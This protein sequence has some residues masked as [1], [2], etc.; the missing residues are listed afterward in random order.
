MFLQQ[1]AKEF[2]EDSLTST[3]RATALCW[4]L[5]HSCAVYGL[6]IQASSEQS[7]TLGFSELTVNKQLSL[8][9]LILLTATKENYK[10]KKTPSC[11]R[12]ERLS[13][14]LWVSE[15]GG[16]LPPASPVGLLQ[17]AVSLVGTKKDFLQTVKNEPRESI[18]K[19][20]VYGEKAIQK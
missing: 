10:K 16:C 7:A 9:C 15:S 18:L 8:Q 5:L 11:H 2:A 12:A 1:D 3:T 17:D 19:S 20:S 4:E 14:Q 6:P 13:V